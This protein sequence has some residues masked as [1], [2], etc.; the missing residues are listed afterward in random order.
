MRKYHN[1]SPLRLRQHQHKRH[2][3]GKYTSQDDVSTEKLAE[4]C[5]ENY[6]K[7]SGSIAS[8]GGEMWSQNVGELLP[9]VQE[10][11]ATGGLEKWVKSEISK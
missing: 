3:L 8:E 2:L 10:I 5:M 1:I 4:V 6:D 11:I 7:T 9:N